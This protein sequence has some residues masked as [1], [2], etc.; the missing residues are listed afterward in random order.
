MNEVYTPTKASCQ[1]NCFTKNPELFLCGPISG[2]ICK[3]G[4]I[5]NIR[6]ICIPKE[7]CPNA[8]NFSERH[9]PKNEAF[10]DGAACQVTCQTRE[11]AK[12]IRCVNSVGCRCMNNLIRD[13]YTGL[14]MSRSAC[15]S[16]YCITRKKLN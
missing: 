1:P 12:R 10:G 4:F 9:C 6:R 13:S 11:L 16:E 3:E 14:C 8:L 7:H 15:P 2:C 5:R